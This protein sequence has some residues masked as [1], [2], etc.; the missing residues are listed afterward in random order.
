MARTKQQSYGGMSIRLKEPALRT[1]IIMVFLAVAS[2][3]SFGLLK[4]D[5]ESVSAATS[6]TEIFSDNFNRANGAVGNGWVP[7]ASWVI[8]NNTLAPSAGGANKA[9]LL[10]PTTENMQNG[11]ITVKAPAA[12]SSSTFRYAVMRKGI[13]GEDGKT[14]AYIGLLSSQTGRCAIGNWVDDNGDGVMQN[15]TSE[16]IYNTSVDC[17]NPSL[18]ANVPYSF[19]FIV[20]SISLVSTKLTLVVKN[21]SGT[22]IGTISAIDTT[23]RLQDT[24]GQWGVSTNGSVNLAGVTAYS[25]DP[26]EIE[27]GLS[28]I[29]GSN[30]KL[31]TAVTYHV[32][33]DAPQ[34]ITLS[35]GGRG[36]TFSTTQIELNAGNS[37]L[38]SFTYTPSVPGN[39]TITATPAGEDSMEDK[40]FVSPFFINIGFI[41]DSITAG[42]A[43]N[44]PPHAPGNFAANPNAT[45]VTVAALGPEFV[46]TNKGV[47]STT[48][49]NWA[50]DNFYVGANQIPVMTN[51]LKAFAPVGVEVVLVMLGSNDS[52][53]TPDPESAPGIGGTSVEEYNGYMQQIITRLKDAGIKKI[54]LNES[55]FLNRND[56]NYLDAS[57]RIS[58]YRGE[59]DKIANG[60]DVLRG[61]TVT[62]DSFKN[63][64]D[65]TSGDGAHP[66]SPDGHNAIGQQ[67][68]DAYKALLIDPYN[69]P[70]HS[71]NT[72]TY[73]F[74]ST[75]GLVYTSDIDIRAFA[76]YVKV[77]GEEL[78]EGKDYT[79][80]SGSTV[81]TLS[82]DYL[83][84][85]PVGEHT[86]NVY[87]L[88]TGEVGTV[89]TSDSFVVLAGVP[90]TGGMP[91]GL[92]R[93]DL[94]KLWGMS[95][96][97]MV[98]GITTFVVVRGRKSA[99]E[100]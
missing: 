86:L 75:D 79:V 64:T 58:A 29:G 17:V 16:Q 15:N 34:N 49:S 78:E 95:V 36:G 21:D 45:A 4:T 8:S 50:H 60:R 2:L 25:A 7:N 66:T 14:A 62:Y 20:E 61:S 51:A 70:D 3:L 76:H 84:S 73:T 48:S 30:I 94:L 40:L 80:A 87:F 83:N 99:R 85:L 22:T 13:H 33:S 53:L 74:G 56:G 47:S 93:I 71:F 46:N 98:I 23:L 24:D 12:A 26:A 55:P 18:L 32:S 90:N 77:D 89:T 38:A 1:F 72:D 69:D 19:D 37:Y 44:P 35:D 97:V 27:S 65:W 10:R 96:G 57:L 42:I 9:P 5:I 88:G 52:W 39:V 54:I 81:V 63:N 100:S 11:K 59:L 82:N 6:W 92:D 67:W 31:G 91:F 68:A 43:N 41:G 28:R